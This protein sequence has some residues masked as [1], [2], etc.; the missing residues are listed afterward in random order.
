[1]STNY[2]MRNKLKSN[3]HGFVDYKAFSEYYARNAQKLEEDVNE[4]PQV[5]W[6]YQDYHYGCDPTSEYIAQ[7]SNVISIN[8]ENAFIEKDTDTI[9]ESGKQFYSLLL[10]S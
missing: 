5:E 1:M 2:R 8:L 7:K 9:W 3:I 6:E 10:L 4:C